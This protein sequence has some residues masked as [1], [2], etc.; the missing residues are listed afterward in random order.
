MAA[1]SPSI[2]NVALRRFRKAWH[3]G[4]GANGLK[5]VLAPDLC[6]DDIE[7]LR[8]H[9]DSCLEAR[10]GE[11]SARAMAAEL[12]QAY[13]RLNKDGRKRFLQLLATDYDI[14]QD[15]L[16]SAID[17]R[18]RAESEDK[19]R[20]AEV[21]LRD[22]LV[23]AR[24]QLINQFTDL[25]QGIK[26]LVDLRAELLTFMDDSPELEAL[27]KDLLNLLRAWFNIGLL[28]LKRISWETPASL[29]ERLIE[30]EAVHEIGSWGN[31]KHRL[32]ED[33][34]CYA[35]FHPCMPG[36]PLI[37]VEVALVSGIAENVQ[38]LLDESAQPEDPD[39]ADT[40]I[41]YSISNCQKGLAGVSF[42]NFLIKRVVEHLKGNRPNLKVFSTLSPIPG[43]R[44]WL[45]AKLKDDHE[46][47]LSE[48]ELKHI[49]SLTGE[50]NAATALS[51]LLAHPEW[52]DDEQTRAVLE[53]ILMRL[54]ASYLLLERRGTSAKD[55]VAHFHLSNGARIERLNWLADTSQRG[56]AQSAGMMVNYRYEPK[57]IES[58][59]ESYS[60]KGQISSAA[61]VRKLL[62]N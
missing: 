43:F 28:E 20:R 22:A 49:A 7:H 9:I 59:H 27:D 60:A 1:T 45:D 11:V 16:D 39:R 21:R 46:N 51:D 40:A 33:R 29:L 31:L 55:R 34:R 48:A 26:F 3:L 35:Y 4:R 58:N 41:F 38:A 57:D 50:H 6:D 17:A 36:E 30:Y 54:C 13:L 19:K 2:F 42:G 37:F 23:P 32:E 14:D 12:G 5:D 24:V 8:E 56:L 10:G 53:P 61:Q 47:T 44:R 15:A 52:V 62:K 25:N 18:H